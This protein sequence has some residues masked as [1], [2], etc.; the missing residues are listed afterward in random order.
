MTSGFWITTVLFAVL[1][2]PAP[3]EVI[4]TLTPPETPF[5][6]PAR[7]TI[8]VVAPVDVAFEMPELPNTFPGLE[9]KAAETTSDTLP[10]GRRRESRSYVLDPIEIREYVLPAVEVAYGDG[11]QAV[12]PATVFRV[13]D[14]SAAEAEQAARFETVIGPEAFPVPGRRLF[15]ALVGAIVA[16]L[17]ILLAVTGYLVRQRRVPEPAAPPLSP[18]ETAYGRLRALEAQNLP[19]S[20]KFELFYIELSAILRHYIEDRFGLR[21]PEQTTPEFLDAAATS[22]LLTV[23]QQALLSAFLRHCDRVKFARFLPSQEDMRHG[24]AFVKHFVRETEV[25][26][27]ASTPAANEAVA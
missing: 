7:Y 8:T 9:V 19:A 12:A 10:D 20:G 22:G 14:L 21:A 1:A 23:E 2:Q 24:L 27:E 18:W 26:P 13:R 11:Q 25:P 4:T 6:R 17:G 5:H 16:A 3:V 15:W